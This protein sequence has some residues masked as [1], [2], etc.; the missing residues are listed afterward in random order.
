MRIITPPNGKLVVNDED[1]AQVVLSE[2]LPNQ[3]YF[4]K[5]LVH[6]RQDEDKGEV[7]FLLKP[8]EERVDK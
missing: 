8:E 4:L 1:E 6:V 2:L 7:S 5:A 3:Q